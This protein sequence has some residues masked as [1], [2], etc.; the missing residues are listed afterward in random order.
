MCDL[1]ASTVCQELPP[2]E[3]DVASLLPRAHLSC[4]WE[5]RQVYQSY[6]ALNEVYDR[7]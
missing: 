5:D 4:F 1:E 6:K 2:S 7:G 3:G